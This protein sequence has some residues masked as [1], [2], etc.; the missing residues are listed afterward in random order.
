MSC[1]SGNARDFTLPLGSTLEAS[2]RAS[3]TSTPQGHA[4]HETGRASRINRGLMLSGVIRAFNFPFR[5]ATAVGLALAI[6]GCT[7]PATTPPAAPSHIA[8]TAGHRHETVSA[9][10]SKHSAAKALASAQ[11][12]CY[13]RGFASGD[14]YVYMLTPGTPAVAQRLGG[15]WDWNVTLRKCLTSVQLMIATAPTG[16]GFCTEVGYVADNPGYNPNA[17]P[18]H[19]L[20]KVVAAVPAGC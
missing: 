5:L 10:T 17:T 16:R 18:A 12:A 13:R 9:R 11:A 7:V 14:I 4:V 2:A 6:I 15:E 8:T 1:F 3:P 19:R 20:A